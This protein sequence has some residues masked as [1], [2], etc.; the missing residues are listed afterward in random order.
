MALIDSYLLLFCRR[1]IND[2]GH[3]TNNYE[4][5]KRKP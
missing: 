2:L 3:P 1:F 4:S 5:I